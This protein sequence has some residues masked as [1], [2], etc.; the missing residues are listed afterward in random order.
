MSP[1]AERRIEDFGPSSCASAVQGVLDDNDLCWCEAEDHVASCKAEDYAPEDAH[2]VSH[3]GEHAQVGEPEAQDK[4]E[5]LHAP[6]APQLRLAVAHSLR[7]LL[8]ESVLH[9]AERL[10]QEAEDEGDEEDAEVAAA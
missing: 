5:A 9:D 2:V 1:Q 4:D 7:D 8:V 3:D 6:L 10:A